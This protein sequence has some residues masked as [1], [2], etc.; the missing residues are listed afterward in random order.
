[1]LPPLRTE[2]LIT[3]VP[4]SI[5]GFHLTAKSFLKN[6]LHPKEGSLPKAVPL[7]QGNP[8]SKY[9][10]RGTNHPPLLASIWDNSE[11]IPAS[12]LPETLLHLHHRSTSPLPG[13]P[14]LPSSQMLLL[15]ALLHKLPAHKFHLRVCFLETQSNL[16]K[17]EPWLNPTL[18]LLYAWT[19]ETENSWRKIHKHAS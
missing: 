16:A 15:R 6:S 13:P 18:H 5:D 11:G 14:S 17:S 1:M 19:H 12:W 2:A 7:L 3:S 8:I 4:S 10:Q 9:L